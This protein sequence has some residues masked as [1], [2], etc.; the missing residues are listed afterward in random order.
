M[1]GETVKPAC[2]ESMGKLKDSPDP[3]LQAFW[4]LAQPNTAI[5]LKGASSVVSLANSEAQV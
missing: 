3:F 1:G 2:S 4:D 5:R